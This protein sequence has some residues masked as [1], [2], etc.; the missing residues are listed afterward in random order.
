MVTA[1]RG[2]QSRST[3]YDAI[4][5]VTQVVDPETGVLNGTTW[6]PGS[7]TYYYD[8]YSSCPTGYQGVPGQLAATKDPNGNLLCYAYDALLRV[9]GVNANGTT[10]RHFYYD[11]STGYG[12]SIPSG[13]STPLQPNGRMVEA[14]TDSCKAN[15]L[16]TDEW[17][18]YDQDGRTTD[19][20]ESTPHSGQYYRS[21]A[22]FAANGVVT[23]VQLASPSLYTVTYG[24]DGEGRL[25]GCEKIDS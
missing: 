16:I 19:R 13:V 20:W 6:V 15:T 21:T 14:A 1:T 18:S 17:F 9:T 5:R 22:A 8:S 23:S 7:W 24:L 10:C 12:T 3:S 11:N 2:L 4:G 25:T